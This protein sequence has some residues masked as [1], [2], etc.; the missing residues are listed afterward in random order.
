MK[1]LAAV[2][3]GLR[4]LRHVRAAA[5]LSS[6]LSVVFSVL[7]WV[8]M[9]AFL[10]DF[11]VRM[12]RI[13][14]GVVLLA[15]L[16]V[17]A[18]ASRRYLLPAARTRENDATLAV[19]IDRRKG[20]QSDLIAALQF[21]DERRR[22]YGS[23]GLR[24]AVV[25]RT[26]EASARLN[27]L[28]GFSRGELS[29]RLAIF[30][31]SATLCLLPGIVYRGHAAAF[32]NRLFLGG[33][34]Y[35]TR[36]IIE[37]IVSPSR[38]GAYGRPVA[39]EVRVGGER[40]GEGLVKIKAVSTG[41][42]T[43]VQLLQDPK[44]PG[45]YVGTLARALDD[46]SYT[47]HVGD[48]YTDPRRLELIPLPLA[49]IEMKILPPAYARGRAVP[50]PQ[51]PRRVVVL[52]GS[53]VVPIVTADKELVSASVTVERTGKTFSLDRRRDGKGFVL[54]RPQSPLVQ[55]TDTLHFRV[56][57][58]DT[59]GLGL[60]E[61][62]RCV[63]KVSHD[64]PPRV[65]VAAYSR[66]VVPEARPALAFQVIDDYAIDR[67]VLHRTILRGDGKVE[68][69]ATPLT[70]P[71]DHPPDFRGSV[72][73]KLSELKLHK[74]DKVV[75]AV[76]AVDYRGRAGGKTKRSEPWTFEVTDEAGVLKGMAGLH[77]EMDKRLDEVLR[78]QLG[79]GD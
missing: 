40:P 3:S 45:R 41:L 43:T 28:E 76:E 22:Q 67:L 13:E 25:A 37:R 75:V 32:F 73:L 66:L 10:L 16:G 55:V 63:V 7:L 53:K 27:F 50:P 34:H 69:A 2:H 29:R 14:R 60:E 36:T 33:A 12:D 65:A 61:P 59:D 8:L 30:A 79:T 47:V 77:E 44:D 58:A 39:F 4:R 46:L 24:D 26:A 20:L 23:G 48:A 72:V 15:T 51:D 71:K 57:V 62:I 64:L 56:Q 70:G 54:D 35:P 6:A 19:M 9:I 1:R 78:A 18:W 74:G 5:R 52:E 31:V 49:E 38:R 11:G 68:R 42:T 17:A 21:D